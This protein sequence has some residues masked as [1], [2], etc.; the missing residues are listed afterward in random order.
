MNKIILA[1]ILFSFSFG[2]DSF[3][4]S[5]GTQATPY[6]GA[7]KKMIKVRMVLTKNGHP[8]RTKN[9]HPVYTKVK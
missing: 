2:V 3:L 7:G 4:Y 6:M 1:I 8:V 9:N 5:R